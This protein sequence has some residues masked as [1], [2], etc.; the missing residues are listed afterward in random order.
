MDALHARAAKTL[1]LASPAYKQGEPIP[2]RYT[3]K[4]ADVSP[5]FS[6]SGVPPAAKA[7]ALILDDPDAPR[8]TWTHWTAWNIPT[9][10]VRLD[11]GADLSKSGARQ[12]V[13]SAGSI[14]YHGPCPPSGTHRYFTRLY[15]LKEPLPLG[16]GATRAQLDKALD[17][18]VLAWGEL[19]GT[20]AHR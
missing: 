15:A 20:F 6:I 1:V 17:G 5:P 4:G 2:E 18:K 3:C 10:V 11:E 8:G 19:M 12:G 13:T 9:K 14:G 7:L 16:E